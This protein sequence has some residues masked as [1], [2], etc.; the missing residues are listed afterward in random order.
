MQITMNDSRITSIAQLRDFLKGV[1][2]IPF[3]LE[4][5]SIEKKYEFIILLLTESIFPSSRITQNVNL[6]IDE[7]IN[8]LKHR[9]YIH[10][11]NNLVCL[12]NGFF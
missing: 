8:T 4:Q 10:T 2:Q 1:E 12:Y 9:I 3:S 7:Y 5:E 6:S 11:L